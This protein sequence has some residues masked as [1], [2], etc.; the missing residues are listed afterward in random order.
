[1]MVVVDVN[2]S[3]ADDVTVVMSVSVF[4]TNALDSVTVVI[5]VPGSL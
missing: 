4:P 2:S 3:C 1:M 5:E